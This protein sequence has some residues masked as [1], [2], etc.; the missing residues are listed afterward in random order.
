MTVT[1]ATDG[2]AIA[3]DVTGDGPVLVL[4]HGITQCRQ[5]WDPLIG[6]LASDHTVVAIDMRG[7]GASGRGATYDSRVMADDVAAVVASLGLP[8]PL[9]VGHSMGGIVVTAY[10]A[11]HSCRGVLNIDQSLALG[12]FQELVRSV[13]PMLR[14]D[15]FDTLVASF[16][17]SMQGALSEAEAER[18]AGLRQ[19]VQEVVLGVWAPVLE[20]SREDLDALV[21]SLTGDVHVPYLALHGTDP[22]PDYATWLHGII[23]SS[24]VEVWEGAGHYP[25]LMEPARFTARVRAFESTLA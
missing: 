1:T 16:I 6:E 11:A 8:A 20:L 23:P 7:H 4:I 15:E 2:V 22:G 18:I 14:G 19:P 13:E 12:D 24:T 25:H 9:V 21:V 17:D 10:A 3:Y 5:M